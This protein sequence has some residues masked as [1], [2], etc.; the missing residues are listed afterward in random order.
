M[1]ELTSNVPRAEQPRLLDRL[2]RRFGEKGSVSFLAT[3]NMLSVG[4]DVPRLGL[5]LMNGQPKTTSEY[6]QATSRVGR[7]DVPGLIVTLFRSTKPRDRSHYE[8]FGVYHRSL[9][10]HVEPTSVT[11]W[12]LPPRDRALH[13]VLTI[14]VTPTWDRASPPR[15]GAVRN[16]RHMTSRPD[17]W[18]SSS[19]RTACRP[20]RGE[21]TRAPGPADRRVAV[22]SERARGSTCAACCNYPSA[23]GPHLQLPPDRLRQAGGSVGDG[24]IDAQCRP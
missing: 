2:G 20:R 8:S 10:R 9:Y 12:S 7:R 19:P 21:A 14:L 23:P 15:I 13:A 18:I 1:V 6:I 17:P 11:P 5:M 24:P 3:T 4:V 16:L 22:R